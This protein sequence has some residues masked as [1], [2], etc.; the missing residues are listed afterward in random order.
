M[1]RLVLFIQVNGR[2]LAQCTSKLTK[3]GIHLFHLF[4]EMTLIDNAHFLRVFG[5]K[6]PLRQLEPRRYICLRESYRLV[7][8]F[9]RT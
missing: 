3:L 9:L 8:H 6:Q 7:V 1:A 5:S 2:R 4:L